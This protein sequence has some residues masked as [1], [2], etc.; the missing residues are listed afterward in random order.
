MKRPEWLTLQVAAAIALVL[1]LSGFIVYVQYLR[2]KAAKF[3]N[4]TAKLDSTEESAEI[5][6]E[7]GE[8]AAKDVQEYQYEVSQDRAAVA[9]AR[10]PD[11]SAADHARLQERI[12]EAYRAGLC[13]ERRLQRK[14]CGPE[15]SAPADD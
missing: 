15:L 14:D 6:R 12:D 13:A 4:V 8:N 9:A 3:D 1:L 5:S 11:A 10:R 7:A 2:G